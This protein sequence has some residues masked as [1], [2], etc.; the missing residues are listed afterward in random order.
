[1]RS[2]ELTLRSSRTM[3][4]DKSTNTLITE[5]G[6]KPRLMEVDADGKI[7]LEFPLQPETKNGHMQTRMARKLANG[8]YLVPH[9]LAF[10]VKEYTPEG[11]VVKVFPTDMSDLGG[12]E[13]K[14]WPFTAIR[15][16]ARRRFDTS[17]ATKA[18]VQNR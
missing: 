17:G 13:A 5:L 16:L 2:M 7:A 6:V 10:K 4:K 12:R 8:N 15:M 18:G 3:T 11:K 9:L 1:M 14:N